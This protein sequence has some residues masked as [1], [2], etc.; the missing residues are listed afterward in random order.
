MKRYG[1]VIK[2]KA[3]SLRGLQEVS[4]GCVAGGPRHDSE[5][6]HTKLFHLSER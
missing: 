4:R 3:E 6:Q 5:M 2:V 1:S